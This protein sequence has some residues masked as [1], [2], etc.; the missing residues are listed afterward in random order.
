MP[1]GSVQTADLL[2]GY[3]ALDVLGL[4]LDPV[5]RAPVRLDRQAGDNGIDAAL[6]DDGAALRPLK[7]VVDVVVDRVIVGH[8][9]CFR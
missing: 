3:D 1:R 9:V 8:R 6:L 4:A 2:L 5:A 7:L